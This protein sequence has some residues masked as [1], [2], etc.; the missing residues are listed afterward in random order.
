VTA[1][2]RHRLTDLFAQGL[3]A[4]AATL[5]PAEGNLERSARGLDTFRQ[6]G[7]PHFLLELVA[8]ATRGG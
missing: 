2:I 1:P 8:T 5:A 4:D 7:L 6:L 3:I